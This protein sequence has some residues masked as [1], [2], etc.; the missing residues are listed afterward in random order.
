[1]GPICKHHSGF[2][3]KSCKPKSFKKL[4]AYD[5]HDELQSETVDTA[6]VAFP[7]APATAAAAAAAAAVVT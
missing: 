1:M 7:S 4:Q 6:D 3:L 5:V 2:F